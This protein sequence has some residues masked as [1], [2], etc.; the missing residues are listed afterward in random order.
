MKFAN[1]GLKA[2][3]VVFALAAA[4]CCLAAYWVKLTDLFYCAKDKISKGVCCPRTASEYD[5]YA[6]WDE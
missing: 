2:L 5:D 1:S 4:A 6:D 3:A